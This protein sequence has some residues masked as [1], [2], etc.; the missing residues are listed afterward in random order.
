MKVTVDM[1]TDGRNQKD[2]PRLDEI[3]SQVGL[4]GLAAQAT[5]V[6]LY[7]VPANHVLHVTSLN[8]TK[9]SQA[10]SQLFRLKKSNPTGGSAPLLQVYFARSNLHFGH[11]QLSLDGIE[12][13]RVVAST[14][15][16][17]YVRAAAPN[18]SANLFV[19]IGGLLRRRTNVDVTT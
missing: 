15:A 18:A 6:L 11:T 19:R 9:N 8:I 2:N 16:V 1:V 10:F 12:G 4:Y 3:R 7:T 17:S 13:L 14:G 5:S